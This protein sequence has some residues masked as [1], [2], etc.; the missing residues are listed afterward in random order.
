MFVSWNKHLETILQSKGLG[1]WEYTVNDTMRFT[2][3][4]DQFRFELLGGDLWTDQLY[5]EWCVSVT[6]DQLANQM[7]LERDRK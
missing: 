2:D 6:W 7:Q 1:E 3:P 4:K 5:R